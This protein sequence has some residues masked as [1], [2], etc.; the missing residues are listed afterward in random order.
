M[1]DAPTIDDKGEEVIRKASGR[2]ADPDKNPI[3]WLYTKIFGSVSGSFIPS[4]LNEAIR[5]TTMDIGT[6][7]LTLPASA[8]SNRNHIKV[9]NHDEVA[10]LYIGNSNV[11]ADRV[12][13]T[14]SGD[15]VPPGESWHMDITDDIVIYGISTQTIRVKI[16]EVA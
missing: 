3:Y 15:E 7:A 6:S 13:G 10:T 14:T 5:V 11:T 2:T 1:V 9:T 4:G 8:L 16:V 12:I